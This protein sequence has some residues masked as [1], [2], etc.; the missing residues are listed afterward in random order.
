[1]LR[2][3]AQTNSQHNHLTYTLVT[4]G[5]LEEGRG[6]WEEA[7]SYYEQARSVAAKTAAVWAAKDARL[8]HLAGTY[9]REKNASYAVHLLREAL[10]KLNVSGDIELSSYFVG[11]LGRA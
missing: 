1:M 4:L 6:N 11:Q 2:R 3:Q 8:G 9:L 7:R 10:P 5:T